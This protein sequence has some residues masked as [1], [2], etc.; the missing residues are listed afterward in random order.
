MAHAYDLIIK[1]I[2]SI[3]LCL[4]DKQTATLG[5]HGDH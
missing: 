1:S 2:N 5:K 3:T 4:Q